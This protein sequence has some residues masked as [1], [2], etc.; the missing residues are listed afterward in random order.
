MKS[1]RILGKA[2]QD[3][4]RESIER[5]KKGD[6]RA[7]YE[8]YTLYS[9]AMYNICLRMLNSREDAEDAL[10][11]A[12]CEIFDKLN[13]FRFESAFGA[14]V[15][16]IVV[17]TCINKLKKKRPELSF[18]EA[19]NGWMAEESEVPDRDETKHT[20]ERILQSISLLPEG[21]RIIFNLHLLEGYDHTEIS[22]ILGISESTS[23]T[24]YMKAKNKIKEILNTL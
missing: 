6:V 16:R 20:A 14:W 15:K 12:F 24:Q 8:L 17:N 2:Y 4:H 19:E 18:T 21:Y 10:Q 23:K 11:D 13:T 7:Q 22:Q 3:I 9:K 1:K 5:S